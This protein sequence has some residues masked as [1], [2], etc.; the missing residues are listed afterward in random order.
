MNLQMRDVYWLA[1]LL[2]GDGSFGIKTDG[3]PRIQL[4]MLDKDVVC[5]AA[6]VL[7][8]SYVAEL[9]PQLVNRQVQYDCCATGKRAAAWMMT[10]YSLLGKRRQSQVRFALQ[11]WTRIGAGSSSTVTSQLAN[12]GE[13]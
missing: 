10:L 11:A 13:T 1:G 7:G 3:Q 5:R 9:Q 2:E 6:S 8:V 4:R 12:V